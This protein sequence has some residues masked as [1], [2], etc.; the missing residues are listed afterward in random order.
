MDG[1]LQQIVEL[2]FLLDNTAQQLLEIGRVAALEVL[3][4]QHVQLDLLR[5]DLVD[6]PRV[7][8]LHREAAGLTAFGRFAHLLVSTSNTKTANADSFIHPDNVTG[9]S[10]SRS[11][12]AR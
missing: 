12:S 4:F 9:H 3:L 5:R 8:S 1:W 10:L 11:A 7:D 2:L 6:L